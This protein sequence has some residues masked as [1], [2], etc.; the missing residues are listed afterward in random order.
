MSRNTCIDKNVVAPL[1]QNVSLLR[2]FLCMA[3]THGTLH[4]WTHDSKYFRVCNSRYFFR[5]WCIL[6]TGGPSKICQRGRRVVV[7]MKSLTFCWIGYGNSMWARSNKKVKEVT[8]RLVQ[9]HKISISSSLFEIKWKFSNMLRVLLD[10]YVWNSDVSDKM[11]MVCCVGKKWLV[12]IRQWPHEVAH[13]RSTMKSPLPTMTHKPS[14]KFITCK[15]YWEDLVEEPMTSTHGH[16]HNFY[17][18]CKV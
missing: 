5:S 8:N 16:I 4:R 11:K 9:K 10:G 2:P 18:V 7:E 15:L 3:H 1:A 14:P 13:V 6:P 12:M 17:K